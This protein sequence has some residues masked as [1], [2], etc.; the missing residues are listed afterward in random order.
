MTRYDESSPCPRCN[1]LDD[2]CACA[3]ELELRSSMNVLGLSTQDVRG[4]YYVGQHALERVDYDLAMI[5]RAGL[6]VAYHAKPVVAEAAGA[7]INH[8]DLIALLY[9]QGYSDSEIIK[10][11]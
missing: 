5:Q 4:Y 3:R 8:N 11:D 7:A 9:L 6:G 10:S 1:E 2:D